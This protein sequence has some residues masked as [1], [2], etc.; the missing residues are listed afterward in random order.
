L[1][2]FVLNDA[3]VDFQDR[4]LA[5]P[6]RVRIAPLRL[7]A[8]GAGSDL[9]RPVSIH[10]DAGIN[11]KGHAVGDTTLTP[12]SLAGDL[13]FTLTGLALKPFVPYMPPLKTLELRS[14][15]ADVSGKAHFEGAKIPALRFTGNAAISDFSLLETTTSSPLFS[16]QAFTLRG[17][18]LRNSKVDIRQAGLVKP[19]GQVV[20]MPDRSF[21]FTPLMPPKAD[22]EEIATANPGPANS[23]TALP[24]RAATIIAPAHAAAATPALTVRLTTLDI[25]G[26]SMGFADQSIQ[27]NFAARIDELKGTIGNITNVPGQIAAIDL[28]GQVIDQFSPATIKGSMDLMAYDRKTDM[29]VIFRNIELPVFNPYSGR[30]AGYAIGKGK[31]TTEL[32]YKIDNRALKAGHHVIIDQLEWGQATESKDVVPL[33]VRLA[34]ALLKDNKGVIDLN[35]PVE[36]SLDDPKFRIWPVIWQIVGNVIVKAVTAPFQLI[37][38]LFAGA[39]K[40]QYIDFAPGSA[41]LPQGSAE[42]LAALAKALNQRPVLKLDIPAGPGTREDAIAIADAAIDRAL[43]ADDAGKVTSVAALDR[44]DQHDRLENLYRSK[45]GKGAAYPDFSADALKAA[46][47]AGPDADEDDRRTLLETQ[48]LRDEMRKSFAPGAPELTALGTARATAVRN[49]LLADGSSLDPARLFMAAN[50]AATANEG[51]SRVELKFE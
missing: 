25:R 27:P 19:V 42:S 13:D 33:P 2:R 30:Y 31:L 1:D 41:S 26:G 44:D 36:G 7:T 8:T 34:T 15:V 9:S 10:F 32:S 40:A 39:D 47:G 18:N 22:A 5:Q 45:L 38:S 14:G 29:Q 48:W 11:G 51:H 21:N 16:W 46:S 43:L 49:A 4:T 23:A 12:A 28:S 3:S 50:I 24:G 17:I 6:A 37:G 35:L 20:V